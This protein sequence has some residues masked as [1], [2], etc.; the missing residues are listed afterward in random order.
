MRNL[1]FFAILFCGGV[2]FAETPDSSVVLGD[3]S[4]TSGIPGVGLLSEDE[5]SRWLDNPANHEPLTV[6]LPKGLDA[7][8]AN[9]FIPEDNPLTRAKIELGRQLFF[10]ER[11][12]SD[13]TI[14]CASCHDPLQAY[15]AETRFGIG[16]RGQEG[17]R[18]RH[19]LL[20]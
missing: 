13:N 3:P 4:L 7:A 10:D 8:A 1:A 20:T 5:L 11:L 19:S 15:G 14:S 17:G 2:V 9:I 6:T 18:N 12:S 16:V